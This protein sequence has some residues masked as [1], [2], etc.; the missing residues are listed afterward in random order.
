MPFFSSVVLMY[1]NV[2]LGLS[3]LADD[4]EICDCS[5]SL[6]V[7]VCSLTLCFAVL[8]DAF[9]EVGKGVT[10]AFDRLGGDEVGS[11]IFASASARTVLLCFKAGRGSQGLACQRSSSPPTAAKAKQAAPEPASLSN[12]PYLVSLDESDNCTSRLP[13]MDQQ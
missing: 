13:A 1:V 4:N 12:Q 2:P 7:L 5:F 8:Q 3:Y 9:G 10:H 6:R 11:I